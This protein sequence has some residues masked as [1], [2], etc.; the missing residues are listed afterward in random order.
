[1]IGERSTLVHLPVALAVIANLQQPILRIVSLAAVGTNQITAPGC[2]AVIV[3]FRD[4]E[5]RP[6][7]AWNQK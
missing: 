3:V 2:A 1:M 6:A 7:A 4:R 5:R